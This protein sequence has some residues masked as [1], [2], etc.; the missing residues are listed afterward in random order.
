[1]PCQGPSVEE[2]RKAQEYRNLYDMILGLHDLAADQGDPTFIPEW[3]ITSCKKGDEETQ[4]CYSNTGRF[5]SITRWLCKKALTLTAEQENTYMY[6]GYDS[7][8]RKFADWWEEHKREDERRREREVRSKAELLASDA[9]KEAYDRTYEE[10]YKRLS[11]EGQKRW[12]QEVEESQERV[13][14][15]WGQEGDPG[16]DGF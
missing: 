14:G 1:M 12:L 5:H 4:Q 15:K 3:A 8:C 2:E 7:R 16:P 13:L 10:E 6:N 11:S 9:S